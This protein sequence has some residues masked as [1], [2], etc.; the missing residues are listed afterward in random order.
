[1]RKFMRSFKEKLKKL[2]IY[3]F[4]TGILATLNKGLAENIVQKQTEIK[5]GKTKSV[6]A[7]KPLPRTF[8]SENGEYIA[9]VE[10]ED[11]GG[12][13]NAHY[14]IKNKKGKT[15]SKFTTDVAPAWVCISNDGTRIAGF[16]GNWIDLAV[17]DKVVFYDFSGR[18]ILHDEIEGTTMYSGEF[19]PEGS[20]FVLAHG[21]QGKEVLTLYNIRD[22]KIEWRMPLDEYLEYPVSVKISQNGEWIL[23]SGAKRRKTIDE[24]VILF[25]KKGKKYWEETIGVS[26]V[27]TYIS[28]DGTTF[29][30]EN[31]VNKKKHIYKN[32]NGKVMLEKIVEIEG[33]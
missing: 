5:E 2:S 22:G 10:Y 14:T 32:I 29:E 33:R 1:M 26:A 20:Y 19:T 27:I 7:N 25:D 12:I 16:G 30:I 9:I 3:L 31:R 18:I 4:A 6:F 17:I 8:T 13:G 28:I 15:L 21:Y 11:W 23:V 24:E